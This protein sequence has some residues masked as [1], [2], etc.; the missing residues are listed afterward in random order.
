MPSLASIKASNA[1]ITDENLP[2]VAVFVGATAGI[3][4]SILTLLISKKIPIRVYILGRN[5]A[6]HK[7]FLDDLRMSNSNATIVWLEGQVSLLSET[8]R[9]CDESTIFLVGFSLSRQP[10]GEDFIFPIFLS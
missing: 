5:G 7:P 1:I 9:L 3:A 6:A 4:K 2:H 10:K 8:R